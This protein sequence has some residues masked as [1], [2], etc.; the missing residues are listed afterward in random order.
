MVISQTVLGQGRFQAGV[1]TEGR[2]VSCIPPDGG[3]KEGHRNRLNGYTD[4]EGRPSNG[5]RLVNPEKS[6]TRDT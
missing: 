4:G 6:A 3:R 5:G 1:N 2:L